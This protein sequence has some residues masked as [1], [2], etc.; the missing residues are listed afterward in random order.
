MAKNI[1]EIVPMVA[2]HPGEIL[3]DEIKANG[4]TQKEF[5][6]KINMQPSQLNELIKGKRNFKPEFSLLLEKHLGLE[7]SIWLNLQSKY[8]LDI[9]RIKEKNDENCSCLRIFQSISKCFPIPFLKKNA[10]VNSNVKESI[11]MIYNLFDVNNLSELIRKGQSD[12]SLAYFRKS[13]SIDS[14]QYCVATWIALVEKEANDIVVNTFDARRNNE[15]FYDLKKL[16]KEDLKII[17][18]IKCLNE[19]GIKVVIKQ[20]KPPHCNVDAISFWSIDNPTIAFTL[21]HKRID[22]FIFNLFHELGHIY[23][24]FNNN[25]EAKYCDS[26]ANSLNTENPIEIEANEF[27]IN[28]IFDLKSLEEFFKK[29]EFSEENVY[30]FAESQQLPVA[31]IWGTLKHHKYIPYNH[32]SK[33]KNSLILPEKST[34]NN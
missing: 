33:Y 24:H 13:K 32:Y 19:F 26:T 5:A 28:K 10:I 14:N 15:L 4:F 17:E 31:I 3:R 20:D 11:E 21:R 25:R 34:I 18:I 29:G 22:N 16:I 23:L 9:I 1:K 7:A 12:N 27:A 6:K 8:D 2:I 30:D